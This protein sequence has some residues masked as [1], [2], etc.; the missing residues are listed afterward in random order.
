MTFELS[1]SN[2]SQ[3]GPAALDNDGNRKPLLLCMSHLRW[4]FVLQRPQHLMT[5]FTERY[6]VVYWEEPTSHP[7]GPMLDVVHD[8][9]GVIVATPRIPDGIDPAEQ[10]DVVAGMLRQMIDEL[11]GEVAV[12]WFYDNGL[13]VLALG[14]FVLEQPG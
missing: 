12:R 14:S 2:P 8:A 13:D 1:N 6:R 7:G 3:D 9:A 5:R 10:D 11:G 4:Q